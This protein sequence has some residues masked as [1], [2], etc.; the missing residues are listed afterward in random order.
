[1]I[2]LTDFLQR[3]M[4]FKQLNKIILIAFIL[5]LKGWFSWIFLEG[6]LP[7]FGINNKKITCFFVMASLKS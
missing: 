7:L 3:E 1:M 5:F 6:C 2:S 4:L